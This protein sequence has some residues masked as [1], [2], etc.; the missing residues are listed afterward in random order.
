LQPGDKEILDGL[1]SG[2]KQRYACEKELYQRFIYFIR[3]GSEKYYLTQEDSFSVYSDT[4]L[5]FIHNVISGKFDGRSSVKTYIFQIF[6]NKCIDLV[7]KN[8]TNK[9]QV[10]RPVTTP[11]LLLQ[12]PDEAR[13]AVELL[14]EEQ[15][16][17]AIKEQLK[18]IGDKCREILLLFEDGFTDK[19]IAEEL[20][21][22]SPAVAKTTRI[23]CIEKLKEKVNALFV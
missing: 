7:R 12:L 10:H 11:D 16:M 19:E 14:I 23:R 3:E 21:Y 18:N 6:S 15:R 13:A 1:Q 20:S 9:Q 22:N 17:H 4:I 2:M 8:T 5:S